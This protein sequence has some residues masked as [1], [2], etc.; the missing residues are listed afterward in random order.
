MSLHHYYYFFRCEKIYYVG[1]VLILKRCRL[2]ILGGDR[3]S[4]TYFQIGHQKTRVCVC[5]CKDINQMWQNIISEQVF[6][7]L[8]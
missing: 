7:V 4:A 1:D 3:M 2:N 8:L 5:V 6:V